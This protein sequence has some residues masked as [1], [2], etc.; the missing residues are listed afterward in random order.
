MIHLVWAL[1]CVIGWFI[2]G[3]AVFL[4]TC[5]VVGKGMAKRVKQ[6]GRPLTPEEDAIVKH[7]FGAWYEA[8]EL[9]KKDRTCR[10]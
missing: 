10:D 6:I 2:W 3:W 7:M 1:V 8:S 9:G 4:F 5:K